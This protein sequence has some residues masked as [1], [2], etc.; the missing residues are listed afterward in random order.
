MNITIIYNLLS[1]NMRYNWR[2]TLKE[3]Y[4]ANYIIMRELW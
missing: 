1:M 4:D 3:V 2:N